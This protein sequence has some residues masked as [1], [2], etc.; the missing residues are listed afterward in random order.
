M[1]N[2]FESETCSRC[3]GSGQFS[4]CQRYGST[5]F[6]CSGNKQTLTKRGSAAQVKFR[7]MLSK[8]VSEL[9]VGMKIQDIGITMGGDIF[10]QWLTI[11]DIKPDTTLYNGA[12]REDYR[13]IECVNKRGE[14]HSI[15]TPLTTVYRVAADSE[16][17][18]QA[19]HACIAYQRSLN[20]S[21]NVDKVL[22]KIVKQVAY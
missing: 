2:L 4:Y 15:G 3:G 5:C 9:S 1:P 7:A 10:N 8:P 12:V 17:K 18:R 6:K 16:T 19:Q 21:G 13:L 11:T 14:Q 20:K 22:A